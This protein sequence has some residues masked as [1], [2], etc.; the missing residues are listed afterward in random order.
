M[1]KKLALV[2]IAVL[3]LGPMFA[4]VGVGLLMNPAA[5]AD[6]TV[7]GGSV[8]V[9]DVPDELDV[10]TRSGE[11]FTL[12][13]DQ[14]THAATIIETGS[15]IE[16]VGR[17]GVKVALMAALTESTLRQLA[18]T[19][20]YP[21]SADY[22]NDGDGS[23]NDSLG[24]FQMRPQSG[25]G[26]VEDLMDP[27]YQAS[28]FYGGPDGPNHGSPRG[29]VDIPGW[30]QMDPAE[31]AQAVEVSAYP[32]RYRDYDPVAET[33]LDALSAS[34]GPTVEPA[35]RAVTAAAPAER[36]SSGVVFPLPEDTWV[37]TS[38]FGPRTHPITGE[39]TMH[40]GSDFA[41]PDGTP[42]LAAAD[43][44]VTVAEYSDASGG[45]VVP[46]GTLGHRYSADGEGR[47]NLEL[48][49]L[50]P[51]LSLLG[52][53]EDVAEVLL[54]RFDTAGQGG[55]GDVARDPAGHLTGEGA[56]TTDGS[57]ARAAQR[58]EAD[59]VQVRRRKRQPA[60]GPERR[61][62]AGGPDDRLHAGALQLVEAGHHR[63]GV[64]QTGVAGAAHLRHRHD[65]PAE[66]RAARVF[67]AACDGEET[68]PVLAEQVG[69]VDAVRHERGR[70][71]RVPVG[72]D[73]Q[74]RVLAGGE[75]Q[76]GGDLRAG[77]A[78]PDH[79]DAPARDI[80]R[81]PVLRGVELGARKAPGHV[82]DERGGPDPGGHHHVARGDALGQDP[83]PGGRA[84]RRDPLHAL[85]PFRAPDG[86]FVALLVAREVV[87]HVV[88]R[89]E[90][91]R[92]RH[93]PAGQV[94]ELGP[95]EQGERIPVVRP[96][97]A[98]LFARVQHHK[99]HP[100]FAQVVG[101]SQAGLPTAD[102]YGV[103]VPARHRPRHRPRRVSSAV[104]SRIHPA[105][106]PAGAVASPYSV[107]A[108][109]FAAAAWMFTA[110]TIASTTAAW[111]K[112]GRSR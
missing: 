9:G 35:G 73:A 106:R 89:R 57:R 21:E 112:S 75:C 27:T 54:P 25:W 68:L 37:A 53:H 56:H 8:E 95:G 69:A 41:A 63:A 78:R 38:P 107:R 3:L 74:G 103:V 36:G 19:S 104:A 18:N 15:G 40:T 4:L 6:C 100:V 50:D 110:S 93:G 108:A 14:L 49:D 79:G 83:E 96:R 26:S 61:P 30:E 20:A 97:P 82:G 34:G 28:A 48:D 62:E 109:S 59:H 94:G 85:H 72:L 105:M 17:P 91:V 11:R 99:R 24:L 66:V 84:R 2:V 33:I 16:G 58:V 67:S 29:L 81:A 77:V 86:E 23:D 7:P 51:A 65:V 1:T 87:H 101:G 98:R 88:A 71:T 31:A 111:Y 42:I 10:E 52:H 70:A 76:V 44:S 102:D 22:P 47:W 92:G 46:N 12:N 64:E 43:G 13:H 80:L 55:R 39:Q 5:T 60:D 32:D 90:A 45:I